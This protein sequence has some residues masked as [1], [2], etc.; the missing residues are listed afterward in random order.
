M[1]KVTSF[2][3]NLIKNL[4]EME[5]SKFNYFILYILLISIDHLFFAE[6]E[7]KFIKFCT[8]L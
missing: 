6:R 4:K 5:Y 7:R 2:Y 1:I 8:T 3:H